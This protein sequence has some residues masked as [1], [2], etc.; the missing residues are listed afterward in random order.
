MEGHCGKKDL[1][2]CHSSNNRFNPN[3]AKE[4]CSIPLGYQKV[5]VSRAKKNQIAIT[6]YIVIVF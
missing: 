3:T 1:E 5:K 2:K 6:F 4:T